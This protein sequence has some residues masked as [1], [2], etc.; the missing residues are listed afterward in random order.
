MNGIDNQLGPQV[1]T[2]RG[3]RA[4]HVAESQQGRMVPARRAALV[5]P[6]LNRPHRDAQER[7]EVT[8]VSQAQGVAKPQPRRGS[9]ACFARLLVRKGVRP[10]GAA[11]SLRVKTRLVW[12]HRR[13]LRFTTSWT[14]A[15]RCRSGSHT[16]LGVWATVCRSRRIR[17]ERQ[18]VACLAPRRRKAAARVA[19]HN[20]V[21]FE[22]ND[23]ASLYDR[24][25]TACRCP[26]GR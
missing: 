12:N 4:P 20:V 1:P 15:T 22:R 21:W 8:G 18:R 17:A 5:L 24:Q 25:T 16:H 3:C 6:P 10:V 13:R 7:R 11:R 23:K 19:R 9:V 2:R 26:G 14:S